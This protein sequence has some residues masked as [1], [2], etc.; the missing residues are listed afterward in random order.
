MR[1]LKDIKFILYISISVLLLGITVFF[2]REFIS[3]LF[4]RMNL[5]DFNPASKSDRVL[6]IAPHCDDE[7]LGS[8]EFIKKTIKEGGNV[9]VAFITN[10]DGFKSALQVDYFEASPKPIEYINF[11]Y[12][13]QKE[14]LKAL[15]RLGVDENDV[16]FLGY[17]DGGIVQL[18]NKN[19]D[20]D[21][22]YTSI[23]SKTDKNP[24]TN[25]FSKGEVY[26]GYNLEN[27]LQRIIE[28][29]KPTY[30]IY[31]HPNDRHP[32]HLA[33][34][35]F[36]KYAVTKLN[37]NPSREL[38][39]L[40][41]RGD[42][43]T[44]LKRDTNMYLVPPAKLAN[45]GTSWY[46]LDMDSTDIEEKTEVIHYFNTQIKLLGP[47][48]TAFERRNELFGVYGNAALKNTGGKDDNIVPS[49]S[50]LIIANPKEDTLGVEVIKGANIISINAERS[51][52]KSIHIFAVLDDEYD[53]YVE[54][55]LGL[56]FFNVTDT[57]RLNISL[58]NNKIFDTNTGAEF[59]VE[60]KSKG[61]ILHLII[62]E[63]LT[64]E[65]Q[66]MFINMNT[67]AGGKVLNRTAWR[68]VES[69]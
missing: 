9:K 40:V 21:N 69:K 45:T 64:G 13:R 49:P 3:N 2:A 6:V 66:H 34:N 20:K 59:L 55:N 1:I 67:F 39:Y 46:A 16:I 62:P 30:I 38:L 48:M 15:K 37:Y 33:S 5:P 11:G 54:Y 51:A 42:W 19:W 43:P 50:N 29:Y 44:P 7:V 4:F 35:A 68:M 27:D 17:P 60:N 12:E 41:H 63:N 57:K 58:K 56:I 14:S 24:Y 18:F 52:S 25:S 22:P 65:F 36:V 31:P 10:G 47:L 8:A 23:G 28:S 61:N 26:C 53:K 32:D